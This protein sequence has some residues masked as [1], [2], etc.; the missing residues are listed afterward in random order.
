VTEDLSAKSTTRRN[1]LKLGAA[2]ALAAAGTAAL[3]GTKGH[4][5]GSGMT[6]DIFNPPSRVANTIGAAKL[7][8]GHEVVLGTFP[9]GGGFFSDSYYGMIGNLTAAK[10]LGT[11][12]LSIRPNGDAFS[13]PSVV[14][15]YSG[16]G[17]YWCNMFIVRFGPPPPLATTASDG[18]III[19]CGGGATNFVIDLI[20]FLGPDQ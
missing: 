6:V 8:S 16:T 10:W 18:K 5:A 19:R 4:A 14:L 1:A 2:A 20:G 12:W 11:G 9:A 15:H 13:F 3:G 7:A 17:Q